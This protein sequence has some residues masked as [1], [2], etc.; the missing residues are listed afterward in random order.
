MDIDMDG[1][2][3]FGCP[4]C[5]GGTAID[6]DDLDDTTYP[7]APEICDDL[8][9][10]DCDFAP[11]CADPECALTQVCGGPDSDGDGVVD[12]DDVCNNTPP[13]LAVDA[14][15]RPLGDIDHD[16]DTDLADFQLFASGF[17]G[18]L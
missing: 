4:T 9:D 13:G 11:D 14:A 17:S 2:G 16:C 5:T 3:Q 12:I 6:C 7:G 18:P 10:N 1:F 15:G 8:I